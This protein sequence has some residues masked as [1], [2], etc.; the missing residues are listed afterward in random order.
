MSGSRR[1]TLLL[2]RLLG[3]GKEGFVVLIRH[4]EN[5]RFR[6]LNV[7]RTLLKMS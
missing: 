4:H 3:V 6:G 2:C 1:V 7:E 5:V